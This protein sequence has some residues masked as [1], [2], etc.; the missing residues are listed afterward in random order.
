M[1]MPQT[2]V[3]MTI[4]EKLNSRKI[5]P[6]VS[7]PTEEDTDGDGIFDDEDTAALTKGLIGGIVGEMTIIACSNAPT[8][9][10]FLI[11]RS[12]VIDELDFSGL[13]GGYEFGTLENMEP[14][15]YNMERFDYVAI[16]NAGA[17]VGGS[18][19]SQPLESGSKGI[20]GDSA[21][22]FFNR[23][24]A[25]ELNSYN[26][27][28]GS[29]YD[30]NESYTKSITKE[31]LNTIII[32]SEQHS[33]YNIFTNNCA[34]VAANSWNLAFDEDKFAVKMMPSDLKSK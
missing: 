31:Q 19:S 26:K 17:G 8:G 30:K 32:Y 34:I 9:H 33:Y 14:G 28:K 1:G 13:T 27:G 25:N 29:P 18:S 23:E 6:I 16:G 11:Y 4:N 22:V 3:A 24:F 12:Y 10:A 21:G 2:I 15:I 5:L 7:D 20:D